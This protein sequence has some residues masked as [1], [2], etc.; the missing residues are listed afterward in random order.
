MS[1]LGMIWAQDVT[2]L[3]GAD[4]DML[5]RVPAD[6]AHFKATTMGCG[7]VMG[8]TWVDIELYH[9]DQGRISRRERHRL[10]QAGFVQLLKDGVLPESLASQ[11]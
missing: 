1:G 6:F 9:Y 7:L 4:G 3:L 8:R 5:W 2:G 10:S 11:A